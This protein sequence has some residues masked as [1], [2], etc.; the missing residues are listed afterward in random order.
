[1][2]AAS[3]VRV[4]DR[5]EDAEQLR[6]LLVERQAVG[7]QPQGR[8][9]HGLEVEAPQPAVHVEPTGQAPRHGH[10]GPPHVEPTGR[11]P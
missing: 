5:L 3:G 11:P 2:A 6:L 9:H 4:R 1:M 10:R 8:R 7:G